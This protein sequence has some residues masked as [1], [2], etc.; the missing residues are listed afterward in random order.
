MEKTPTKRVRETEDQR[1]TKSI[2]AIYKKS[3]ADPD[4][5]VMYYMEPND[6]NTWYVKLFNFSGDKDEYKGGEYIIKFTL[7]SLFPKSEPPWFL[8]LTPNGTYGDQPKACVDLG[9]F[10]K[11]N[12]RGV[13]QI[14]KFAHILMQGLIGWHEMTSGVNIVEATTEQR[15][16]Y[17]RNSVAY[18]QEHYADILEN[19]HSNFR[20]YSAK[21]V[22]DTSWRCNSNGYSTTK[23]INHKLLITNLSFF[24]VN[25]FNIFNILY[26]Q[27]T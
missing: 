13:L 20:E 6:I 10:H 17:A 15:R 5:F 18:N 4:E 3:V 8:F 24:V 11:E 19:I 16:V 21:W 25:I 12:M 7:P 9:G 26:K 23:V 27:R 1:R 2:L 14:G 22:E